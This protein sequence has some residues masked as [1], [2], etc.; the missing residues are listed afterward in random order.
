[1]SEQEPVLYCEA[2]HKEYSEGGNTLH[3]LRGVDLSVNRGELIAVVGASGSGKTTLLN[4]LGGLDRPSRGLVKVTGVDF[5]NVGE[6]Q[7]GDLRNRHMGFVYQMHHL[8]DEFTALENVAMPLLIRGE[9]R[10]HARQRAT[11]MLEQVGLAERLTHKPAELSGGERQRVAVARALVGEPSCVLMD[12]PTGN[13]DPENAESV[14]QLILSL[15]RQLEI[16]FVVVTHDH[17]IAKRMDRTLQLRD[18][19]LQELAGA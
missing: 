19:V 10:E 14:F 3:I 1:M 11:A 15:N 6:K 7:R 9:K 12:E 17:D 2:L 4:M 8:L 13:L 18:G 5:S 16:S